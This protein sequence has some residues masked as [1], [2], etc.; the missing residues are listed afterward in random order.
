MS[1]SQQLDWSIIC[2][3]LQANNFFDDNESKQQILQNMFEQSNDGG[4]PLL[5]HL[6]HEQHR[7][8]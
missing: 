1:A 2:E 4:I 7:V 6:Q 3:I 8:I 5:F